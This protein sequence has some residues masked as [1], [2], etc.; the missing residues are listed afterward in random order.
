MIGLP[1][2]RLGQ[3]SIAFTLLSLGAFV[4]AMAGLTIDRSGTLE[5]GQSNLRGLWWYWITS[6]MV[7][8][9]LTGVWWWLARHKVADEARSRFTRSVGLIVLLAVAARVIVLVSH[10]PSLSD[11]VFR[12]VFD[13]R[14]LAAG[15]NPYLVHP[16]ERTWVT[17]ERWP[18]ERDLVPLLAY[19]ELPTPYLP[20]S[21]YG[22]GAMGMTIGENWS[23]PASS[24]LVFRIGFVSCEMAI[25][26][27]LA[28]ALW[29]TKRSPWLLALYAWHPLPI[30]E[31]AGSGHQDI[32]GIAL[33]VAGLVLWTIKPMATSRWTILIALSAMV[34]PVTIPAA[35]FMLRG[36]PWR[37][38]L[39]CLAIA[40][41]TCLVIAAPLWIIGGDGG[42]AFENWRMTATFMGEKSAHFA[43]PYE[44]AELAM[45]HAF[46]DG[47]HRQ[48]GWNLVQEIRARKLCLAILAIAGLVILFRKGG[49]PWTRTAALV[50]A[51]VLLA[52]TAQPWYLL[53]GFALIPLAF[54]AT[55]WVYSLTITFGYVY[56]A[57]GRGAALGEAWTVNPWILAWGYVPIVVTLCIELWFLRSHRQAASGGLATK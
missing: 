5:A 26:A 53:W 31:I 14:N 40:A 11:D 39:K 6:G 16:I 19:P 50:L 34:K 29:R 2:S 23:D 30:A 48:P 21:Q 47:R 28:L 56:F 22:F 32:L 12:Y 46:P 45:R 4:A 49:D 13:G 15:A 8:I 25:L 57:T 24:A 17:D 18:G 9:G 27:M 43:G 35:A 20:L 51:S 42:R 44:V 52:P 41:V 1:R 37:D 7:W 54:S 3:A 33:L 36:R 55:M 10:E 38:W